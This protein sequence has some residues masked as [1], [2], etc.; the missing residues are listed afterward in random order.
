M[1]LSS[2]SSRDDI[3]TIAYLRLKAATLED[4]PSTIDTEGRALTI[5]PLLDSSAERI[6]KVLLSR[7]KACQTKEEGQVGGRRHSQPTRLRPSVARRGNWLGVSELTSQAETPEN[8]MRE[9]FDS[10]T[11]EPPYLS[12][13][14]LVLC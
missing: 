14:P 3:G 2:G 11:S 4:K 10:L 6:P 12:M 1:V 8:Q 7:D 5:P 9:C 13:T